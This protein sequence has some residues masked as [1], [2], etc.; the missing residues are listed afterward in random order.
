MDSY[1]V[2]FEVTPPTE[3]LRVWRDNLDVV[4][5]GPRMAW[6]Y[7]GSPNPPEGVFCLYA[8]GAEG[9]R[10]VGSAGLL[11]R[12]FRVGERTV[13][14]ALLADLAVDAEHRTLRPAL[15]LARAVR[16]H[17]LERY[18]LVY[19][20]AN[21]QSAPVLRRC[22][23]RVKDTIVRYAR[24]LRHSGYFARVTGISGP[25]A[26][27]AGRVIDFGNRA[28]GLSQIRATRRFRLEWDDAIDARLAGLLATAHEP[29]LVTGA[30]CREFLRWRFFESGVPHRVAVLYPRRGGEPLACAVLRR[31]GGLALVRDVV[32]RPDHVGRLLDLAGPALRQEGVGTLS[33]HTVAS[34]ALRATLDDCDFV[35]R[36]RP[37]TLLVDSADESLASIPAD[38]WQITDADQDT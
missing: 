26:A 1:E 34:P 24:V 19:G 18:D 36:E 12:R 30:R 8:Q 28:A 11:P 38:R 37:D 7:E 3:T 22:G 17:A 4:E 23:Y 2:V 33:F 5:P 9:S 16:R 27:V 29:N 21:A 25:A 13:S 20:V 32:G 10:L 15:M 6:L 31:D 14:G 35:E